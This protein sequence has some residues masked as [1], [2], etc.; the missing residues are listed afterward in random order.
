MTTVGAPANKVCRRTLFCI[1]YINKENYNQTWEP[2]N[3]ISILYRYC[4]NM[5][6]KLAEIVFLIYYNAISYSYG[7]VKEK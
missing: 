3:C 6:Y 5:E 7:V 4:R 2:V 1:I